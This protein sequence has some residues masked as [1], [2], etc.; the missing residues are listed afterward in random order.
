M[1][2]WWYLV[3]GGDCAAFMLGRGTPGGRWERFRV[4]PEGT[5]GVWAGGGCCLRGR[6]AKRIGGLSTQ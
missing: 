6:R 5:G 2:M 1:S 4:V 3:P